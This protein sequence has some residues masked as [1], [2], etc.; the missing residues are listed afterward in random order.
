MTQ[1]LLSAN[2]GT[3]AVMIPFVLRL[4]VGWAF[5]STRLKEKASY[6]E[7]QQRG[8]LAR[9]DR[10]TC[11]GRPASWPEEPAPLC[12]PAPRPRDKSQHPSPGDA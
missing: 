3:V 2:I 11:G 10:E 1:L 9:K 6:Y 8:L 7:A 12:S 5:V 4:R